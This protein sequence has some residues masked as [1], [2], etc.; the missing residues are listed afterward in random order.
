M[1]AIFVT[2][3][4][5]LFSL[6]LF[7]FIGFALRRG[8]ILDKEASQSI[9]KVLVWVFMPMLT[10]RTF[11]INFTV[12]NISQNITLF[13]SG[14]VV[15]TIC[16]TIAIYLGRKFGTDANTKAI[17]QYSFAIPNVGYMGYPM[18]EGVF[19]EAMLCNMM[20]FVIPINVIIYSW[21]AAVLTGDGKIRPKQI[22]NAP[23]ISMVL[24]ILVGLLGIKLPDFVLNAFKLGA[25][26]M[27]P[28]AMLIA[29]IVFGGADLKSVFNKSKTYV[30][31]FI[32]L[33]AF[34]VVFGLI[35]ILLKCNK[36]MI[37][38]AVVSLAMPF[39]LNAVVFPEAAGKDSSEG[40]SS[41]IVSNLMGVITIPILMSLLT[42]I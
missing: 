4:E 22:L 29:G 14:V 18:M 37:I 35:M 23:M 20:T 5:Q 17:Y 2:T 33:V 38:C 8:K 30:A 13:A 32:R 31:S 27:A 25:D 12:E 26:C 42:L 34:P 6:F 11:A 1:G 39:G 9:S 40:A 7:I 10:F 16:T 36:T 15:A 3:L 41:C 19:G 21:G 28:S 24:G